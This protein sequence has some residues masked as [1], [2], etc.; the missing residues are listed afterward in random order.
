MTEGQ[1]A[2]I[3]SHLSGWCAM[4]LLV[5]LSEFFISAVLRKT[6]KAAYDDWI[7]QSLGGVEGN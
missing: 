4:Q 1:R 2:P 7:L 6:T 5:Y 3:F